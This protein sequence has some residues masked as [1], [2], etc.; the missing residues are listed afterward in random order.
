MSQ[1]TIDHC[2]LTPADWNDL[3]PEQI[4]QW[5]VI[6]QAYIALSDPYTN[7]LDGGTF[8]A[9][10][11]QQIRTLI[12]G[13]P[14]MNQSYTRPAFSP[15]LNNACGVSGPIAQPSNNAYETTPAYMTGRSE[16]LCVAQ[17]Y[18]QVLQTLG[19]YIDTMKKGLY[20]LNLIDARINYHDLSG[21]KFVAN[22]AGN[23]GTLLTGDFL[24][25]STP[26]NWGYGLPN[27]YMSWQALLAIMNEM[28][29][30]VR[31][32]ELWPGSADGMFAGIFSYEQI[33]IFRN[34]G[35]IKSD[36]QSAIKGSYDDA[37][38]AEW[39]YSWIEYPYRGIQFG[40]DQQPLR[41]NAIN[42]DGSPAFID[43]YITE[44]AT[45][46]YNNV[47]NP[48]WQIALYEIGFL[49][50]KNTLRKLVPEDYTGEAQA[51]FPHQFWNGELHWINNKDMGCNPRGEFG[52]FDYMFVRAY[53][54]LRTWGICAIAYQRC[55][56]DIGLQTCAKETS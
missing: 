41:F 48:N 4:P 23:I 38:K 6:N 42:A 45:F 1:S 15:W 49:L 35:D 5:Q 32:I 28:R 51:V 8:P 24:S 33:E 12:P 11:G 17:T 31:D 20:E 50:T 56:T 10:M 43:P 52:Y 53:Q 14:V 27:A 16:L 55:Q 9:N 46:G 54:P 26:Y 3:L 13:R 18:D 19:I 37:K 36:V 47:V 44:P 7:A 29:N 30:R 21:L 34:T 22:T 2:Q 25:I 39:R 40:I